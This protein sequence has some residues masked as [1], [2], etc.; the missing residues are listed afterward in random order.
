MAIKVDSIAKGPAFSA[1]T[2]ASRMLNLL[3][4]N[5]VSANDQQVE[6][7]LA[8][9]NANGTFNANDFLAALDQNDN[10]AL[11]DAVRVSFG[12]ESEALFAKPTA[13]AAAA[14][15]VNEEFSMTNGAAV[16]IAAA[17]DTDPAAKAGSAD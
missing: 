13:V 5:G 2:Q 9:A 14:L 15:A 11:L 6:S 3:K 16:S 12:D 7:A 10:V 1:S 8:K 17:E 4:Q